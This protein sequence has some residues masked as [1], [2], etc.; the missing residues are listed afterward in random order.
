MLAHVD[1]PGFS[2][3]Q[4]RRLGDLALGQRGG[5]RKLD[6]ALQDEGLLWQLLALRLAVIKCHAR[7]EVATGSL[8]LQRSGNKVVLQIPP[9]WA[10]RHPRALYLLRE[11]VEAWAK[12]GRLSLSLSTD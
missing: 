3:N 12:L 11:E 6:T 10:A 9:S 2:Q 8:K 5:L 1:A 4:L 7:A